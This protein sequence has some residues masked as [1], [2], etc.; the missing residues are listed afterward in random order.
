MGAVDGK[1]DGCA[2]G[3]AEGTAEGKVEGAADGDSVG[4]WL[5]AALGVEVGRE[6]GANVG[7]ELDGYVAC[8][9]GAA[10]SGRRSVSS[11]SSTA[12]SSAASSALS[13]LPLSPL[14][15]NETP[16]TAMHAKA[17]M[18]ATISALRRHHWRPA[19]AETL[20][21]SSCA[22]ASSSRRSYAKVVG[23]SSSAK[24]GSDQRTSSSAS[25]SGFRVDGMVGTYGVAPGRHSGSLSM[26]NRFVIRCCV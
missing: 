5:G 14:R 4:L 7:T 6:V 17:S 12:I 25:M 24:I 23:R 22:G 11:S 10:V 1:A 20:S 2:D 21:V 9:D 19:A 13:P 26:P 15:P 3:E 16:A 18:P 8:V